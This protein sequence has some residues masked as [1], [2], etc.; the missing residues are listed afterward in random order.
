MNLL[1]HF[2]L[3]GPSEGIRFGNFIGDFVKGRQLEQYQAPVANGIKLHR[4]ID[5]FTDTHEVVKASKRRL[6]PR[7]RHYAAVIVDIYYDHFLAA[8]WARYSDVPLTDFAKGCYATVAQQQH[9]LPERAARMFPYMQAGNWLYNYQYLEGIARTL[10][11]MSRR[12]RF[13]S[14][15]EEATEELQAHYE[16][17]AEEFHAFMP[18]IQQFAQGWLQENQPDR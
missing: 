15:I 4:Q 11:G 2:Y 7:Y 12:S 6:Q 9:L 8:N 5:Q 17:F 16:L 10:E 1:A 18:Q 3:S 13:E 14:G